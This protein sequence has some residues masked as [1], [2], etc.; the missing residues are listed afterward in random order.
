[1]MPRLGEK[2]DI[3]IET[4]SKPRA[5][6]NTDEYFELDLG[7]KAGGGH[8]QTPWPSGAG[9]R[10]ERNTGPASRQITFSRIRGS[11]WIKRET[12]RV[13]GLCQAYREQGRGLANLRQG[14]RV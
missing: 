14:V 4:I 11:Q 10:K 9:A 5:D 7:S 3:E 2:Y 1:M 8:L 13:P 6:Y 12:W